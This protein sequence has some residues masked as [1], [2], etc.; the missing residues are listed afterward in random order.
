MTKRKG[1]RPIIRLDWDLVDGLAKLQATHEEIASLLSCSV[2]TL[3]RAARREHSMGFA[4]YYRQKAL[5]GRASLRRAQFATALKG[6]TAMLI[7]LGK[8]YL[9][10][11]EQRDLRDAPTSD[12]QT[13]ARQI[14]EMAAALF[15][16]GPIR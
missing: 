15:A 16:T 10:Q 7:W 5:G 12:P 6:N 9:E 2:D 4:E 1:G 13:I 8:Q 11:R 14:R 3:N